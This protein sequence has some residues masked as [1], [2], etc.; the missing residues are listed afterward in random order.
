MK[1]PFLA[2]AALAGLALSV[3]AETYLVASDGSGDFTSVSAAQIAAAPGDVIVV[4][5]GVYAGAA[6]VTDSLTIVAEQSQS[7]ILSGSLVVNQLPAGAS[8]VIRG[9]ILD[10][11]LGGA[12]NF[13]VN[14]SQGQVSFED[15][16]IAAG[17]LSLF[18]ATDALRITNSSATLSRCTLLNSGGQLA[19]DAATLRVVDSSVNLYDCLVVGATGSPSLDGLT[20]I[21]LEGNVGSTL[22]ASGCTLSGG[23]GGVGTQDAMGTCANGGNGGDVIN[24]G[25]TSHATLL[26]TTLDPGSG[27]AAG[28]F[29]CV[30]GS[31]GAGIAGLG[32]L[33]EL[34]GA[35]RSFSVSSPVEDGAIATTAFSGEP[36]DLVLQGI[37]LAAANDPLPAFSGQL[38][39][40]QPLLLLLNAGSLSSA[41]T[42]TLQYPVALFPGLTEL[43]FFEQSVFL[44]TDGKFVLSAPSYPTSIPAIL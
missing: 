35:A 15:C 30:P 16:L 33:D 31:D 22:F 17:G 2:T 13:S 37:S 6:T 9:M 10:S 20:S 18:G 41:G 44:G 11:G 4:R 21:L 19:T 34:D 14:D 25:P 28:G 29:T 26:D 5:A 3:Q 32:L 40:R 7:A 24:I 27:G 1:A 38:V 39:I 12:S 8:V 43:Q 23:D 42:L 36:F